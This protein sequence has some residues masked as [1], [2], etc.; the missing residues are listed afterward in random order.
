[1][2]N[3]Q[4]VYELGYSLWYDNIQRKL[5]ENGQLAGMIERGEIYGV[6]SNPSIFH[7]AIAKTNDYDEALIPLAKAGK[8][9]EEIFETLAVE[10]I[11][12]AA[13]LFAD[14]YK[15]TNGGDGYVSL[16]V[17]PTL[18]RNSKETLA[19]AKRLW[20]MVD[21]P[22]LMIK[23]P[24]TKEGLPAIRKA[25]AFGMNVNVTLIFSVERYEEV[26]EAYISGLEDRVSLN[27]DIDKIAS[28][29]SF[30]ISRMDSN[31]DAQLDKV[32]GGV[33][34]Q[35]KAAIA[36]AKIAYQKYKVK[37]GSYRFHLLK[38]INAKPQRPLWA[39]TSTKNPEYPDTLYI[40]SLVGPETVNTVPPKTLAAFL[41]HGEVV[42]SLE[43]GI[44]PSEQVIM[45]I[46]SIGISVEKVTQQL[47]DEGVASFSKSYVELIESIERRRIEAKK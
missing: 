40:D 37:F 31:I 4:K 38:N 39:S 10:D 16:E 35:G 41:D 30:F 47:E 24:A 18:A 29:A 13:D 21:R 3:S 2:N 36:N 19:E 20:K 25:I 27:L 11:R 46:E 1:M 32:K 17:N 45:D 34:F 6:T 33:A 15:K 22:N 44:M 7:N 23:I 43:K 26:M 9:A 8:S 14:L 5:L 12:A 28:V 42:F